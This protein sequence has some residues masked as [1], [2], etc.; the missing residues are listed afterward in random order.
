M[1]NGLARTR[2]VLNADIS[3]LVTGR[4]EID[5]D[6]LEELEMLLVAADVGVPATTRII[7]DLGYRVKLR[8]VSTRKGLLEAPAQRARG[9][10]A[11]RRRPVRQPAPASRR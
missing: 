4:K 5:D 3:E 9:D 2:E 7:E 6:L 8:E 1:R 10:P 11:P